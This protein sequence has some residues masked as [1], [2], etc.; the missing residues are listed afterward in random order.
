M[1][2]KIT[3]ITATA[4]SRRRA[5]PIRDALQTLDTDSTCNVTIETDAG[6]RGTSSTFFGRGEHSAS[7]L[8]HLIEDA[9]APLVIGEDAF[10]IRSIRDL[11]WRATDYHGTQGLALF[12]IA[13]IDVALWD[14]VGKA[15]QQP[16]WRLLGRTARPCSGLRD[17]GLAQL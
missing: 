17:G 6:V 2:L 4:T 9:L 13:A 10:M 7:I 15:M 12:G 8:A 14:T 11:L 5:Q 3:S 1:T 16:V